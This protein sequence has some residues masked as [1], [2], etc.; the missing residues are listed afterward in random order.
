MTDA[1]SLV[2]A[3]RATL[4]AAA[5]PDRAP[6][7]QAYMKSSLPFYGVPRPVHARA[8]R[9]LFAES[10]L[11]DRASW[12][13]AIGRLWNEATHREERYAA[14]RLAGDRRYASYQDAEAVTGLY[15]GLI[16]T[17]AWWDLVDEVAPHLVGPILLRDA[18]LA[19]TVRAWSVA[20]DL[21]L[22][23]ASIICQLGAKGATDTVLLADAIDA[24]LVGTPYGHEFFVRKAI[25]W[26]LR[27][28][29]RT[30][31]GWVRAFV[32]S[33]LD[34]LAPLSVREATKHLG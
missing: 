22:R 24:N 1:D 10:P 11:P 25:G 33:R 6:A 23:R 19:A 7:M 3:T 2:D 26:A 15:Q 31:A 9:R 34:A 27:Q 4:R 18:S 14:L 20:D 28:H 8:L 17:G 16:V 5:D 30:D 32:S 13:A 29:A 21:W 12:T